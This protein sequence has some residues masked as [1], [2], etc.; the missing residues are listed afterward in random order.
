VFERFTE[1]ARH[2]VVYAQETA[3]E[4]IGIDQLVYGLLREREGI[5]ARVLRAAGYE[6][7]S[8]PPPRRSGP[9]Q[10]PFTHEAKAA[11]ERATDEADAL[12]HA[13]VG[14]E[15]ILMAVKPDLRDAVLRVLHGDEQ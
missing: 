14:T 7:P 6:Q 1:P 5:G 8:L 2:V 4:E 15:H 10:I 9:G 3:T 12:G 13:A 11:L